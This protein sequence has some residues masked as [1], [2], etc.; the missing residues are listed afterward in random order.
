M[1]SSICVLYR[2]TGS[3]TNPR[4]NDGQG[5]AGT[6]RSNMVMQADRAYQEDSGQYWQGTDKY[7]HWGRSYPAQLSAA[8]ML[9]LGEGDREKLAVLSPGNRVCWPVVLLSSVRHVR[10]NN[11]PFIGQFRGELSELDDAGTYFD[12]GP[13]NITRSG[14][15]HYMCTRNNNFSN[16]SQKGR[17][18]VVDYAAMSAQIGATGGSITMPSG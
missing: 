10:Y 11:S 7:G 8:T 6:D 9:G 17:I 13:R 3:N 18:V 16:R 2:W 1:N 4:N 5:L 12:L 15:V 14:T